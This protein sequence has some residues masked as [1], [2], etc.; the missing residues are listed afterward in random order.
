MVTDKHKISVDISCSFDGFA[1]DVE[2]LKELA[3]NI[4]KRFSVAQA[5]V[6]IAIVDDK[7]IKQI[8]SDYLNS[9]KPTDVISFDL[10]DED[11]LKSF[12]IIINAEQ[13]MHQAA[14]RG[15]SP[16]AELALYLTHGMLHNLGF[17]DSE[18]DDAKTM[19]QMEDEILQREGFGVVYNREIKND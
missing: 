6:S 11:G 18:L 5:L 10:S 3:V 1:P 19:H 4:C 14:Q 13:A 12:E 9:K 2:K 7:A 8:N 17:N 15:H 16:E